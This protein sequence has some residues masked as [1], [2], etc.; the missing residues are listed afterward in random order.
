MSRRGRK[1]KHGQRYPSGDLRRES[2]RERA[3]QLPHRRGLPD[4]LDHRAES[5]LGRMVLRRELEPLHGLAGEQYAR[6]FRGYRLTINGPQSLSHGQGRFLCD[7]CPEQPRPHCTCERLKIKYLDAQRILLGFGS[8]VLAIVHRVVI[9][10][11]RV[12]TPS[13][14]PILRMGLIALADHYGLTNRQ[15][16][17]IRK[18]SSS[19]V[20]TPSS[21]PEPAV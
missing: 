5:E 1:R 21:P 20:M 18:M 11:W 19:Q 3:A 4:P 14:V 2:P 7:G 9:N 16:G 10:D 6:D 8:V 13:Q 12:S 17:T 15:T